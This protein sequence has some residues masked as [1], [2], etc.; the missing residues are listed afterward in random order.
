MRSITKT[1]QL[2]ACAQPVL[3]RQTFGYSFFVFQQVRLLLA[4]VM[5]VCLSMTGLLQGAYAA[6]PRPAVKSI[7]LSLEELGSR[8]PKLLAQ[9]KI[10]ALLQLVKQGRFALAQDYLDNT[11]FSGGSALDASFVQA[12][13]FQNTER[14]DEAVA[15]YRD[16]L[17]NHPDNKTARLQL[18]QT[19]YLMKE[20]ESAKHHFE[21][22]LGSV[23]DQN[24]ENNIRNFIDQI[25]SRKRWNMSAHLSL[26]P[27]TNFNRGTDAKLVY[28]NGLPFVINDGSR[29][30]SGIGV[31]G[32]LNAGYRLALTDRLDLVT[33][34]GVNFKEYA[35]DA[36]DDLV[37]SAEVGP[38]YAFNF[39]HVGVY[40]TTNRRWV[41]GQPYSN[42]VGGRLKLGGRFSKRGLMSLTVG[43]NLNRFEFAKYFDGTSYFA[44]GYVDYYLSGRSFVRALGGGDKRQTGVEH[45]SSASWHGGLGYYAELPWGLSVYTQARLT[46]RMYDG[47]FPGIDETRSDIKL[48]LKTSLTKRDW[49]W[50]GFAPKFE[51]GFTRN[52]SN[53]VF[54][55]YDAHSANLTLTKKF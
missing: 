4:I 35:E 9:Q 26:A 16:I 43:A 48:D 2:S 28:L 50:M 3:R 40:A 47:F 18:A 44:S 21:L 7:K 20:D 19:L 32:G 39:G 14:L 36:F 31:L 12:L 41:A 45:L 29:E 53:V 38:R 22:A 8:W 27:S 30:K 33:G 52:A 13:I 1:T 51:Y 25:D 24:L 23:T 17:T 11:E 15:I 55:D 5:A 34:G 6:S 37:I 42:S 49:D 54:Y 10:I 46:K